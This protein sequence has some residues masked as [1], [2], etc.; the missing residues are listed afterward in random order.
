MR[1]RCFTRFTNAKKLRMSFSGAMQSNSQP[2]RNRSQ[3]LA[4][5]RSLQWRDSILGHERHHEQRNENLFFVRQRILE[6]AASPWEEPSAFNSTPPARPFVAVDN[7]RAVR[8]VPKVPWSG[9]PWNQCRAMP[10]PN[11]VAHD[12]RDENRTSQLLGF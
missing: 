2:E 4:F 10:A 5:Q 1:Q 3:V 7:W 11:A 6:K 12:G 9:S 8:P